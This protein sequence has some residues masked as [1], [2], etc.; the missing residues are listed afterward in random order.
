MARTK[1]THLAREGLAARLA[2][3]VVARIGREEIAPGERLPT[4]AEIAAQYGVSRTVVR[5]AI[6]RLRA[7]GVVTA[8]PGAGTFV[9]PTGWNRSFRIGVDPGEEDFPLIHVLEL[10][11]AFEVEAARLAAERRN[12]DD[13][14]TMRRCLAVMAGDVAGT[15]QGSDADV[16]FHHAIAIAAKNPLFSDFFDFI[17]PHIRREIR[18]A[19]EK[20]ARLSHSRAAGLWL[21]AQGEHG[22]I[23][24][25]IEAAEPARAAAAARTHVRNTMK[26]LRP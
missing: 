6:S 14:G 8:R 23:L 16:D 25:A 1:P 5:E 18:V 4:E 13:L 26:R 12:E 7:D 17:S 3:D 22:A 15:S 24:A 2:A 11:M 10:R 21:Q 9:T 20:T 19:R